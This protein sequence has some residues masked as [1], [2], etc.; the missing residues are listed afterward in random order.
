[1][2]SLEV[3]REPPPARVTVIMGRNDETVPFAHVDD[4]WRRWEWTGR[5]VAGSRFIELPEGDHSLVSHADIIRDAIVKAV[6]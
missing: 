5:L 3:D 1:M 6:R 2:A 4:T